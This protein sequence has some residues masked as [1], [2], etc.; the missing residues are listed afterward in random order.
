MYEFITENNLMSPNQ[1][2]FK[3]DDSCL[4]QLLSITYE[5]Y[6]SFD[7]GFEV[8]GIF[9]NISKA[10]DK[11]WHKELLY[12]L[13]QNGISGKLFGVI[14]DFLNSRKQR[15]VLNSQCS[16]WTSIEAGYLKN[17]YLD[18]CFFGFILVISLMI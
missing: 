7:D 16:S 15:V 3:P 14:T 6:K 17:Q 18:H 1:S 10:F 9:I 5:I 8:W 2:G 12:K 11:V 4:K 13:E